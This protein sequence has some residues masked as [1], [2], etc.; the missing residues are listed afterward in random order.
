MF[1]VRDL[2]KAL[3]HKTSKGSLTRISGLN[4]VQFLTLP[5]FPVFALESVLSAGSG[6]SR[7]ALEAA[8]AEQVFGHAEF[9]G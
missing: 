4:A 5:V 9:K 2:Y 6:V 1:C 3:S 8:R 7:R